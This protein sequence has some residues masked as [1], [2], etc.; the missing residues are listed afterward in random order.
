PLGVDGARLVAEIARGRPLGEALG[1]PAGLGEALYAR[2]HTWFAAGRH[3]RAVARVHAAGL[4]A[5]T[6]EWDLAARHLAAFAACDGPDTP[7][8]LRREAAQLG[9]AVA[10]RQGQAR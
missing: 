1:L 6:D 8:E 3:D 10:Q 2:A 5:A 9:R 4:A 7:P